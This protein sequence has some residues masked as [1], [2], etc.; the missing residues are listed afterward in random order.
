MKKS[1]ICLLLFTITLQG[2]GEVLYAL[3]RTP[4][5][6]EEAFSDP[7]R[8]THIITQVGLSASSGVVSISCSFLIPTIVGI[9]AC[10][11]LGA[12]WYYAA[13][14]FVLEPW[15]KARV[16]EGKPSLVGPYWERGP[17]DGEKFVNE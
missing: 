2:C 7:I 12:I 17:Q 9:P 5:R 11:A 1:L 3:K 6:T 10:A 16:K 14:E 8:R 13:Y 15:S 4:D